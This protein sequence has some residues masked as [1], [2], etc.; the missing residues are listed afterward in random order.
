MTLQLSEN[1][2]KV[3]DGDLVIANLVHRLMAKDPKDLEASGRD[4]AVKHLGLMTDRVLDKLL[5]AMASIVSDYQL[6]RV[7]V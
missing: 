1:T 6:S 5:H 3:A 7:S 4:V 2:L